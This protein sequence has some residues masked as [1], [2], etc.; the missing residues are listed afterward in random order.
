MKRG[1]LRLFAL[2]VVCCAMRASAVV[3]YVDLNSAS[4]TPPYTNWSTAA[5]NIQDA[6]DVAANGDTIL[7]TAR[8][9]IPCS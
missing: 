4:S 7:V 8:P 6:V 9:R 5:T 2:V 1:L 3:R